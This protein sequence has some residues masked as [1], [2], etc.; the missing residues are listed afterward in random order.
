MQTRFK[1]SSVCKKSWMLQWQHCLAV[2]HGFKRPNFSKLDKLEPP[3]MLSKCF[4]GLVS[5][6]IRRCPDF[7]HF[8]G[9]PT[10][11]AAK[12]RRM[13]ASLESKMNDSKRKFPAKGHKREFLSE[14]SQ[15][16]TSK[17]KF[18]SGSSETEFNN[19][20]RRTSR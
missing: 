16:I 8:T 2:L 6:R 3:T 5:A 7:S 12:Q 11:K 18:P 14:G 13:Q 9:V 15:A 17:R 19:L 10:P 20:E 1:K 4:S